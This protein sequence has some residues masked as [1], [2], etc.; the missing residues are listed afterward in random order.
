MLFV[1]SL[2]GLS[3]AKE[4]NTNERDLVLSVRALDQLV[5]HTVAWARDGAVTDDPI[6]TPER[7]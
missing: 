7:P 4:E 2:G 3:H 5:Q 6:T 1:Q